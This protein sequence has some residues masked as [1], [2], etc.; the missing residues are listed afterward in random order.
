[1]PCYFTVRKVFIILVNINV[2]RGSF[3]KQKLLFIYNPFESLGTI[4]KIINC[5]NEKCGVVNSND[6]SWLYNIQKKTSP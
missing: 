5:I 2:A 6:Y 4:E 3:A 1:M